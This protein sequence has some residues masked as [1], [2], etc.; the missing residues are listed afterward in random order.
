MRGLNDKKATL[1]CILFI[2]ICILTIVLDWVK[3]DV[4]RQMLMAGLFNLLVIIFIMLIFIC[5][6]V[7]GAIYAYKKYSLN[8]IIVFLP[9][10]I[11]IITV[12]I[13][14]VLPL[15]TT[16][17]KLNFEFNKSEFIKAIHMFETG[18]MRNY[19]IGENEYI[20]PN[21]MRRI[22]HT[23]S[24][25]AQ[26]SEET[27]KYLFYIHCGL[28]KSSAYIYV[29]DESEIKDGDFGCTYDKIQMLEDSWYVVIIND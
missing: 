1:T 6:L 9:L 25:L 7:W 18:E 21:H 13:H 2:L 17:Q 26:T 8:R 22:S 29:S 24:I 10:L 12:M 23:G 14:T 28:G 27:E 5:L 19:Q 11:L 16:Y 3:W 20:L 4:S 15:T